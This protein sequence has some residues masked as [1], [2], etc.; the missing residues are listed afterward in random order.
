[1]R[2]ALMSV[3]EVYFYRAWEHDKRSFVQEDISALCLQ[4]SNVFLISKKKSCNSVSRK[5][6]IKV[7]SRQ[8]STIIL[9]LL[10]LVLYL[11]LTFRNFTS[12]LM[13]TIQ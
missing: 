7:T 9:L 10:L 11:M 8:N 4:L 12:Q 2:L 5:I 13:S 3:V 6:L 1:M